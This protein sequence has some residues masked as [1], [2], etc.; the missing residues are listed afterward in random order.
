MRIQ[1]FS[2][3]FLKSADEVFLTSTTK[4]I[5]PVRTI[6][7]TDFSCPGPLTVRMMKFYIQKVESAIGG[8]YEHPKAAWSI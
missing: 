3:D 5:M 8:G 1:R 4:E 2:L 7:N 6:D